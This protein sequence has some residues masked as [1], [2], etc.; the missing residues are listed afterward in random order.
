MLDCAH[1]TFVSVAF[2]RGQITLSE[3]LGGVMTPW[4]PPRIRHWLWLEI[5]QYNT[6][7]MAIFVFGKRPLSGQQKGWFALPRWSALPHFPLRIGVQALPALRGGI[8][9]RQNL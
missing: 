3:L 5:R 6:L 8:K 2:G 7:L 9:L 1:N 4:T